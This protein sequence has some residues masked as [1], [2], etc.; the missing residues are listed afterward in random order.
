MGQKPKYEV[1]RLP[2]RVT[3]AGAEPKLMMPA[4]QY[5]G[6]FFWKVWSMQ[7][8]VLAIALPGKF[9]F[10]LGA[11][12]RRFMAISWEQKVR[13]LASLTQESSPD[14]IPFPLGPS[15]LLGPIAR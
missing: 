15:V 10:F 7:G 6:N 9:M 11:N 8:T 14:N 4:G 2:F 13:L 3:D 1:P 5:R 12:I